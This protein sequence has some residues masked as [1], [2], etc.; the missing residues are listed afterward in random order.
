[1]PYKKY[2]H[3]LKTQKILVLF[4]NQ[5]IP[6]KPWKHEGK[7]KPKVHNDGTTGHG[8]VMD[9]CYNYNWV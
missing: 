3:T 5:Y 2:S 1:M 7:V 6:V 4:I 9:Q 8:K